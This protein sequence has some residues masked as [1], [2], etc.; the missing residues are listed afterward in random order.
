MALVTRMFS[1]LKAGE[2]RSPIVMSQFSLLKVVILPYMP[3]TRVSECVM[4]FFASS[5]NQDIGNEG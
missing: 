3:L 4:C 1:S 2:F 5:G